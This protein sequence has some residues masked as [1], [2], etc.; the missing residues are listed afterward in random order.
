MS[1]TKPTNGA[2]IRRIST[3]TKLRS[4]LEKSNDILLCPGVYDRFSA[5][6]ALQVGFDALYMV[7]L[8]CLSPP[9]PT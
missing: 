6:I 4:F 2:S 1:S 8:S 9:L 5:R 7:S 3:A